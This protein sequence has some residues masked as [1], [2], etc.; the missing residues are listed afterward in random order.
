MNVNIKIGIPEAKNATNTSLCAINTAGSV[1]LVILG[2]TTIPLTTTQYSNRIT[3]ANNTITVPDSGSYYISYQVKTTSSLGIGMVTQ[4]LVNG[5]VN[6]NLTDS[7]LVSTNKFSGELIL[8][9][10]ANSTLSL[11]FAGVA[12][13]ATLQSNVGV[14]FNVIKLS[15]G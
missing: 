15:D 8:E 10:S 2:G 13:T 5:V 1:V 4:V 14:V 9:L 12:A 6:A 11:R 3:L 7:P